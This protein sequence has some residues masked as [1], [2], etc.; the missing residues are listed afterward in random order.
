MQGT[1]GV[2]KCNGRDNKLWRKKTTNFLAAKWPDIHQL[3]LWAERQTEE[4]TDE[5][6]AGGC[7]ADEKL[8]AARL[9]AEYA[10]TMSFHLWGFLNTK[11]TEDAWDLSDSAKMWAGLEVW[12]LINMDGTQLTQAETMNPADAVL[13]PK[14]LKLLADI[15]KGLVA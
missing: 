9:T 1:R 11:L 3:L 6:L 2:D 10:T 7:F 8:K 15:P 12:R 13:M 14:R 5:K 4:I